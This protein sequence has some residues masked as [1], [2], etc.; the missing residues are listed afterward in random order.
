MYIRITYL[1][2]AALV[3]MACERP[4]NPAADSEFTDEL[5]LATT[6]VK[7]QGASSVCWMYAMLSTIETDRLSQGDSVNLSV[8]FPLRRYI[9]EGLPRPCSVAGATPSRCVAQPVW[10]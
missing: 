6:P 7:N 3:M 5:R 8:A 4:A 10:L 2:L 1:V 9:E